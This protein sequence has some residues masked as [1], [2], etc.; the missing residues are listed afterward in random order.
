MR[1]ISKALLCATTIALLG[2]SGVAAQ[3]SDRWTAADLAQFRTNMTDARIDRATQDVLENKLR[4]QQPLDS[5]R[6]VAPIRT[7]T[8]DSPTTRR[9]V[10]VYPDGSR[11]WT[12][13]EVAASA[14]ESSKSRSA[15]TK[16]GTSGAWR[17]NCRVDISDLVSSAWFV[18][19]YKAAAP[20]QIRDFRGAG[21]Q[22]L[23][24]SCTVSGK[25]ERATQNGAGPAWAYL[26]YSV[27][28]WSQISASGQFGI[29]VAN[30]SLSTY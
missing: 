3:A 30:G 16:C 14:N 2:G 5:M 17:V 25:I 15:V 22:I 10:S 27:Y 12:E 4:S 28:T 7:F 8:E 9:T 13:A 18:V 19:D 23:G 6:D 24:G 1:T 29:R 20:S 11:S 21:C 26:N